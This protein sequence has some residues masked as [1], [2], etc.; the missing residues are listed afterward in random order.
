MSPMGS[1]LS[2]SRWPFSPSPPETRGGSLNVVSVVTLVLLL[3]LRPTAT[4]LR[5]RRERR[6]RLDLD[7]AQ[8]RAPRGG[9][10]MGDGRGHTLGPQ[11]GRVPGQAPARPLGQHLAGD[12]GVPV[13]A[14]ARQGRAGPHDDGPHPRPLQLHLQRGDESFEPPLGGHVGRH[15]RPRVGHDVGRHEDEVAPP[16]R[17]HGGPEGAHQSLRAADVDAQDLLEVL[18]AGLE[19]RAR[20]N[21][22]RVGHEDLDRAERGVRLLGEPVHRGGVGQV[23]MTGHRLSPFGA[24]GRG[25]LVADLHPARP[26][27]HGVPHPGQR[28]R[29]LGADARRGAGHRR[30][31]ALGM[32]LEARHQRGVTVVGSAAKPR[33]LMEWTRAMP[34]G[35][36]S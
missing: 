21:F 13:H 25:D 30:R 2:S 1:R 31:P 9:H 10:R 18:R 11:E 17:H 26:E 20:L 19:R 22:G 23:E 5:L 36:M 24:D 12:V 4:P 14:H 8:M 34:A 7:H 3:P 35:S 16:A 33:T 29:R 6:L 27:H 32:G 28:P 15:A